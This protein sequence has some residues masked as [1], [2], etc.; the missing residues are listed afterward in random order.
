MMCSHTGRI[1]SRQ[2]TQRKQEFRHYPNL[3]HFGTC[4]CVPIFISLLLSLSLSCLTAGCTTATMFGLFC[5]QHTQTV[6]NTEGI[7]YPLRVMASRQ[8]EALAGLFIF[9]ESGVSKGTIVTPRYGQ[10]RDNPYMEARV[11]GSA[12][13]SVVLF[14]CG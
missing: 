9:V 14:S 2:E 13:L 10:T 7:S 8:D 6:P 5:E 4:V 1:F 11:R 12:S 3:F